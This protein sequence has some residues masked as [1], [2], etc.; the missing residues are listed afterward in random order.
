MG[1]SDLVWKI[2]KAQHCA[3][4][5]SCKDSFLLKEGDSSRL[6]VEVTPFPVTQTCISCREI[7][8][9]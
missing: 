7:E 4:S 1:L 2:K 3:V 8:R 5:F 6:F 9:A